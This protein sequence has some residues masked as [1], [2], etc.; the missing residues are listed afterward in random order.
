VPRDRDL[1]PFAAGN[2]PHGDAAMT[3]LD[4]DTLATTP[5]GKRVRQQIDD[6]FKHLPQGT[7]AHGL[8]VGVLG[9]PQGGPPVEYRYCVGK[10]DVEQGT[11]VTP[12]TVFEIGSMTKSFTTTMLAAQVQAGNMS[13]GDT[14]QS[15]YDLYESSVTLP[16]YTDPSTGEVVPMTLLDLADFTSGIAAKGP[17]NVGA[18]NAY[19]FDLLHAYLEND[20]PDGLPSQPGTEFVYVNTNFGIIAELLMLAGGYASYAD[21]LQAELITAGQLAMPSTGVVTSNT[22]SIPNLA[23]G[24]NADGTVQPNFALNSW[25]ALQGAGAI[26]STLDDTLEWLR[27]NMGQTCS[28]LNDVLSMTQQQWFPQGGSGGGEGLG[29]FVNPMDGATVISKDGG[30]SGFHSWIGFTSDSSWGVVVLCN[31]QLRTGAPGGGSPV[32]ALGRAILRT[33]LAG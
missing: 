26:Y 8:A 13:L 22:P 10:A 7:V 24:Y 9:W 11:L 2:H 28:P 32:D 21:L 14:A 1:D 18:P 19:T 31:G 16:V 25:P 20:F 5:E 33:L 27:F 3:V 23:Q 4:A 15:Y 6:F 30:T 12:D 17:S 29:W